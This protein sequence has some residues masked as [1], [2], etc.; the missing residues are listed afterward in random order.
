MNFPLHSTLYAILGLV[1]AAPL[2]AQPPASQADG[3]EQ[4]ITVTGEKP[5][6]H[7][8]HQREADRFVDSHAIIT[9]IGQLARWHEPICVRT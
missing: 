6:S 9:R 1:L 4:S 8:E 5:D 2:A 3:P 7:A